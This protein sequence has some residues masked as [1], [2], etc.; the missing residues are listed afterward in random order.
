[1]PLADNLTALASLA[2]TT[3]VAAAVTDAWETTRRGVAKLLGRGDKNLTELMETRLDETRSQLTAPPEAGIAQARALLADQ[4]ATRLGDLLEEDP[5]ATT[6]LQAL[7]AQIQMELPA[8]AAS[9]AEHSAVA[10]RDMNIK[11]SG[12]SLAA[13]VIHGDVAPPGPFRPGPV[14]D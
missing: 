8:G 14:S 11:A 5:E 1:M 4:W 6:E 13:G 2:G 9:A 10:G 3:V 7:I 12:G